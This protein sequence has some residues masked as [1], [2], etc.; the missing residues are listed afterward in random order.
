MHQQRGL[1]TLNLI[2]PRASDRDGPAKKIDQLNSWEIRGVT[3][4]ITEKDLTPWLIVVNLKTDR[5]NAVGPH[6]H[7]L[8]APINELSM[9]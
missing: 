1:V 5:T 7:L 9:C 6:R 4:R 2:G 8:V 3:D